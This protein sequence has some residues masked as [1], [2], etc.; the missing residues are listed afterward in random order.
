MSAAVE[1]PAE[2]RPFQGEIPENALE[3]LRRRIAST[4]LPTSVAA[5]GK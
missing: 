4:H 2:I 1:A 3:D 5:V